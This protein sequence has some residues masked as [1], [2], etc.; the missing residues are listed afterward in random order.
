MNG[1]SK[2]EDAIEEMNDNTCDGDVNDNACDSD[3]K[4]RND[5]VYHVEQMRSNK[6]DCRE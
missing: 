5:S 1:G 3:V 4:H 2:N 6:N